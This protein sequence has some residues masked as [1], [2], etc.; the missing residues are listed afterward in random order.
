MTLVG[1][2]SSF[3]FSPTLPCKVDLQLKTSHLFVVLF[4]AVC[5]WPPTAAASPPAQ[6]LLATL[7]HAGDQV[8]GRVVEDVDAVG[9]VLEGYKRALQ[10]TDGRQVSV[11]A[12]ALL[13]GCQ[14]MCIVEHLC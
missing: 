4:L 7:G 11:R 6:Q 12:E 2:T 14:D 8:G 9:A 13:R 3:R 5:W 10:H 1:V